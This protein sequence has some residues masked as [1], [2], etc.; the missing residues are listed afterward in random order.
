M[1]QAISEKNVYQELYVQFE[2]HYTKEI[3]IPTI[4]VT[5]KQESH[6]QQVR[7]LVTKN[8]LAFYI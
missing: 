3:I 8:I 4:I 5:N 1:F 7:G 2:K 6:F